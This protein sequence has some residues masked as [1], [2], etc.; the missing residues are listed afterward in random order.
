MSIG[1]LAP[2]VRSKVL[3]GQVR[4]A[5]RPEILGIWNIILLWEN[6]PSE[7]RSVIF[8][9]SVYIKI[10]STILAKWVIEKIRCSWLPDSGLRHTCWLISRSSHFIAISIYNGKLIW[11]KCETEPN[12]F[13]IF[14]HVHLRISKKILDSGVVT[15]IEN[16]QTDSR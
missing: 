11:E 12:D 4:P 16:V 3:I 10:F 6:V 9:F 5:R 14:S 1:E 13:L 8:Y 7:F 15:R 2:T